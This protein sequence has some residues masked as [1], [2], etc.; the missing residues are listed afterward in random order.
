M[1]LDSP[2]AIEEESVLRVLDSKYRFRVRFSYR[3]FCVSTPE[4]SVGLLFGHFSLFFSGLLSRTPVKL[5]Q[6]EARLRAEGWRAKPRLR[7]SHK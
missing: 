2:L 6:N 7:R 4:G 5:D 1:P 3:S